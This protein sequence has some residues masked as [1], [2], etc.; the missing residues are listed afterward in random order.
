MSDNV[1]NCNFSLEKWLINGWFKGDGL[2]LSFCCI[3]GQN[4]DKIMTKYL[5]SRT[6]YF[7]NTMMKT[8]WELLQ[9]EQIAFSF[10]N[11]TARRKSSVNLRPPLWIY[12]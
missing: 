4:R 7:W 2:S 8:L 9:E 5:C 12:I 10:Q 3:L 6:N 11:T 1:N